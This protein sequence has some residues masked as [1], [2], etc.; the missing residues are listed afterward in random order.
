M[1]TQTAGFLIVLCV[2]VALMA[3]DRD[4]Q[5]VSVLPTAQPTGMGTVSA[6]P[7]LTQ[8]STTTVTDLPT[9]TPEPTA[10]ETLHP[11]VTASLIPTETS[12]PP[13]PTPQPP[14]QVPTPQSNTVQSGLE[15]LASFAWENRLIV[16]F[17]D[18]ANVSTLSTQ[19]WS[20]NAAIVER[21]ILWFIVAGDAVTTN[22][23]GPLAG[24]LAD[25]LRS[26]YAQLGTTPEVVLIGKDSGVKNR[27]AF[28]DSSAIY[29]QIDQ[30]PM[31]RQEMQQQTP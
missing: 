25:N 24:S 20:E 4:G 5:I 26:R 27:R 3:C 18:A 21:H 15:T 13:Q 8:L 22:Y 19:L 23:A 30:M 11:T 6:E 17:A 14:T 28:L 1:R 16:V 10:T 31:R 29:G 12:E 2:T 7:T 9:M